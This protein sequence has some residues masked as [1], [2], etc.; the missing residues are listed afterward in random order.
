M[1]FEPHAYQRRAIDFVKSKRRCALFLDMG[2]GKTVSTLTAVAELMDEA[3]V[4]HT[5]VVAPK[6]VAE[7]TWA[8][9]ASKWDHLRGLTVSRVMGTEKQRR[10]ALAREADIYVMSRDSVVWFAQNYG[11]RSK[12]KIDCVV[13][14]ELTSFKNHRA[15]RFRAVRNFITARGVPYVIGLTGTPAPNSLLDLWAEMYCIDGGERL[16]KFIGRYREAYF[17]AVPIGRVATKY[18]PR[19]GAEK[20]ILERIGDICLTMQAKDYLSLPDRIEVTDRVELGDALLKRYRQFERDMV[21]EYKKGLEEGTVVADS[22]AGLM[23]KLSQFANGAVYGEDREVVEIHSEKLE[24]LKEIIETATCPVLVFYQFQHDRDRILSAVSGARAY[25]GDCD[26]QEWNDGS[27]PVL[28]AHPASTAYG[29]NMQAGGHVAVW[30]GTGWN[31][32]HYLQ[33]NA[34]LHRQGQTH[35]VTIHRLVCIGTADEAALSAIDRKCGTQEGIIE[36]LK[37]LLNRY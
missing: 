14:D 23:N 10:E 7:S 9:E 16:G 5:L 8:A 18:V 30:Y 36:T 17:N 11:L 31:L 29:L 34:R 20:A 1:R 15:K 27:I 6:K 35:P 13:L 37:Q 2:L 3:E 32:E 26:L 33:A 12:P 25:T 28:L 19:Q 22:A 24:R 4:T 21:L